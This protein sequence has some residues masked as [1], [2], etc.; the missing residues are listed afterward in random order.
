ML[1]SSVKYLTISLYCLVGLFI[2]T[3]IQVSSVHAAGTTTTSPTATPQVTITLP[4]GAN[5]AIGHPGTKVHI[6]GTN[7]PPSMTVALYTTPNSDPTK[8]ISGAD[9]A[10]LGL[11]SFATSPTIMSQADGTFQ[12]DPKWPNSAAIATT[13]YYICA[14]SSDPTGAHAISTTSFTVAQAVAITI[15]PQSSTPVAPGGQVTIAGSNWLPPQ[16]M[17]VSIVSPSQATAIVSDHVTSDAQGNFSIALTIPSTA[18]AGTYSVSVIA[19]NEP[20][21]KLTQPNAVVVASAATPTPTPAPSPTATATAQATVTP[22]P[23]PATGGNNGG[24]GGGGSG[25]T[26]LIFALGG[27]GAILIIVGIVIFATYSRGR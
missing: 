5:P 27:I 25:M 17:T 26:I 16:A 2:L 20:T 24:G 8:C 10:G 4:S 14:I 1:K 13:T 6:A 3:Y 9:T 22:T 15:T 19:D 18:P 11:T 12:I 23:S 7:F 21:M